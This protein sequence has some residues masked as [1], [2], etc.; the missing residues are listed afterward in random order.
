M[1]WVLLLEDEPLQVKLVTDILKSQGVTT[2]STDSKEEALS[3]ALENPNLIISDVCLKKPGLNDNDI[4]KD[5]IKFS[6]EIKENPETN[7]IPIILRS[8]MSLQ[9]FGVTFNETKAEIFLNKRNSL[10]DFLSEIRRL[11][12]A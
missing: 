9:D 12:R 1:P 5:G 7:H 10:E 3:W 4:N 8:S 6:Q 2:K 11:M